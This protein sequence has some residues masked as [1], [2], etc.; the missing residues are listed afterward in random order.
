MIHHAHV[1]ALL[2]LSC[3]FLG[4]QSKPV[5]QETADPVQAP[6]PVPAPDAQNLIANPGF[7]SGLDA[8]TWL[9]WSKGWAPYKLSSSRVRSGQHALHLPI[10]S[11]A[12]RSTIVWG[13]VQ[14]ITLQGD[15]PECIEGYYYVEN[16]VHEDWKQY[17]QLVVIDLTH[18]LGD[19]RGDAQLRY[20]ISGSSTPP[21]SISNAQYLFVE[22]SESPKIGQ[23][24]RF[25]VNP[26]RDFMQSWNY[27]PAAGAKLR[28]L[29]EGRYDLH[30]S[31]IPAR[32]DVFYDDLYFGPK[33]ASHCAD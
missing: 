14:E 3:L 15:I 9:D 31:A 26:R 17:L 1:C 4:C 30:K 11:D 10:L 24:T 25:Q 21:L 23:W 32:G 5:S 28:I 27:T 20:V 12:K 8:W 29:F 2:F 13:G 18:P 7:E 16:W 6:L 19:K 33:T 22:R